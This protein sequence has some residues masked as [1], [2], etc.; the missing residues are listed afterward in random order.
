MSICLHKFQYNFTKLWL[1]VYYQHCFLIIVYIFCIYG[2]TS[3]IFFYTR[4]KN[5]IIFTTWK[6]DNFFY[7][8][9][10]KISLKTAKWKKEL[11]KN[12]CP[13]VN[14]YL[15]LRG[16]CQSFM[17]TRLTQKQEHTLYSQFFLYRIKLQINFE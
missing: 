16:K 5:Q 2:R 14:V 9:K 10:E 13:S 4:N 15:I 17:C 1:M 11:V 6:I 12:V 3:Q 7:K 8:L